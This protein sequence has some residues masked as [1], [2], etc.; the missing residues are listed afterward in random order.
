MDLAVKNRLPTVNGLR[1]LPMLGAYGANAAD[2]HRRAATYVDKILRSANRRASNSVVV[3]EV[4]DKLAL[5]FLC[6][7]C[8]GLEVA[9]RVDSLRAGGRPDLEVKR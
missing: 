1:E 5:L 4:I 8:S 9:S 2:L 3:P 6:C 7:R